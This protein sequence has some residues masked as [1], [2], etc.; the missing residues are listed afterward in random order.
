MAKTL[1]PAASRE[2]PDAT[3]LLWYEPEVV[4]GPADAS[5]ATKQAKQGQDPSLPA[6][7]KSRPSYAYREV[8]AMASEAASALRALETERADGDMPPRVGLMLAGLTCSSA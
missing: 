4:Q 3:A 7:A 5:R 8:W 2:A 1:Q 6:E